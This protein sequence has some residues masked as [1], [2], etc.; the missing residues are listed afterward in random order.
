MTRHPG[1]GK[2]RTLSSITKSAFSQIRT[3]IL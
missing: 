2:R 3:R 1:R